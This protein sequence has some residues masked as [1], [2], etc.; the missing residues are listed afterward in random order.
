MSLATR[1]LIPPERNTLVNIF[2]HVQYCEGRGYVNKRG[3]ADAMAQEK[4]TTRVT[5]DAAELLTRGQL[6]NQ[7][8]RQQASVSQQPVQQNPVLQALVRPIAN[9]LLFG[10][11]VLQMPQALAQ[12]MA[13]TGAR[14]AQ[15]LQQSPNFLARAV[16]NLLGFFF[17]NDKKARNER[18]KDADEIRQRDDVTFADPLTFTAIAEP[19][20][21]GMGEGK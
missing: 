1:D 13:Q 10:R 19:E 8:T 6:I 3:L 12:A 20:K 2:Q 21:G 16:G 15:N 7:A 18:D 9:T 4:S 17:G 14:M 5:R 11:R